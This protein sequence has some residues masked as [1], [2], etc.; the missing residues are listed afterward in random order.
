MSGV[1]LRRYQLQP[2]TTDAFLDAWRAA[3][4]V[5][6]SYGF[7]IVAAVVDRDVE[8]FVWI[9]RHPDDFA[10]AEQEYYDAP[11]RAALPV[12]PASFLADKWVTM[13]ESELLP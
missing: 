2:G 8:Q 1:Q 3:M 9:V 13:V 12:D 10:A 6:R 7:E 4:V 11:E 5:R